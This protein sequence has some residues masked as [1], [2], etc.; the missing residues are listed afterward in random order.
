MGLGGRLVI[1]NGTDCDWIRSDQ[2][3]YQMNSWNFPEVIKSNSYEVIYIE[4]SQYIF[5]DHSLDSASVTY[6]FKGKDNSSF[7]IQARAKEIWDIQIYFEDFNFLPYE[8][9]KTISLG[10]RHD[11]FINF[12]IFG[13]NNNYI[14]NHSDICNYNLDLWADRQLGEICIAGSHDA[15]MNQITGGTA[16][17]NACNTQTQT[18]TILRQLELGIRYFDIRPVISGAHYYTGHYSKVGP[19]WQGCNGQSIESII[20]D[21]N[22]F[23]S[24]RH[25]AIIIIKLSHSLNTDV[26]A[27]SYRGFNENEWIG[28]FYEMDAIK[29]KYETGNKQFTDLSKVK[30]NEIIKG[31]SSVIIL[32]DCNEQFIESRLGT[33]FFPIRSLDT[34]DSYS[35]T[36]DIDQMISDQITKMHNNS[37]NRFFLISWTLTQSNLQVFNCSGGGVIGLPGSIL[38]LADSANQNLLVRLYPEISTKTYPNIIYVDNVADFDAASLAMSVNCKVL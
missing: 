34:Y 36:N 33:G 31:K 11:G 3:S 14:S 28:L 24:K 19:T 35:N 13:K 25:N 6:T 15:G 37:S 12:V 9:G 30:L 10:F 32:S 20:D 2:M 23:T 21:L 29:N 27:S 5:Y 1:I 7:K 38:S 17:A 4:W 26:G 22:E 16:F 8:N 18:N